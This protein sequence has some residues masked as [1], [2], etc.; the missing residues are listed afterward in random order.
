MPTDMDNDINGFEKKTEKR[1]MDFKNVRK[2]ENSNHQ[3]A[4][5][6]GHGRRGTML[7]A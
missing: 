7:T 6:Y 3:H 2:D 1:C 5:R 4:Y